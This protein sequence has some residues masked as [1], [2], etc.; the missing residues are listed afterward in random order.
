[1]PISL[2]LLI[3]LLAGAFSAAVYVH[4]MNQRRRELLR[5]ADGRTQSAQPALALLTSAEVSWKTRLGEWLRRNA[6]SA[7]SA[8]G[9][10]GDTL[11][12][13]GYDGA[14][15]PAVYATIRLAAAVL[16]PL[17]VFAVGP[18][19]R[20]S[21]LLLYLGSALVLGVLGPPGLLARQARLRQAQIRRSLPDSLDL[22]VVCV[23]AGVSLDAAIL[24]VAREMEILHPILAREFLIVNRKVNAGITREAAFHAL[25][26]RTG[27]EELRGLASS[28]IQSEKWGTSISTVLRVYAESLR[29]KRKQMA[30]KKA[31]E[32]SVK[33]MIPLAA[34]IFP[35]L[36]VVIAGSAGLEIYKA[37]GNVGQ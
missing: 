2:I 6:P 29:R 3:A 1:M 32:A 27:V 14:T 30:E 7:W 4:Q 17:A 11:V 5:R 22:L 19:D 24:R 35:A 21:T 26:T 9:R 16:P 37:L 10:A 23:E 20:P 13:A 34:L 31:A 15:A 18:H 36:F 12:H 25:W 8:P 33:L 28:M